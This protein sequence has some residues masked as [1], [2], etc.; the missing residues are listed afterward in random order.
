MRARFSL[1]LAASSALFLLAACT[2][3]TP[4][5]PSAA[6]AEAPAAPTETVAARRTVEVRNPFGNTAVADNLMAD[7][8]FELTGRYDQQPWL[9]FGQGGQSVLNFETGGRCRSGVRC[10]VLGPDEAV[11]GW[12][13]TPAAGKIT[14]ALWAR[15]V[16]GSC[17]DLIVR[18]VDMDKDSN[19]AVGFPAPAEDERGECFFE[20]SAASL[21]G[22]SPAV[23]LEV[24][25]NA[26]AKSIVVDDVVALPVAGNGASLRSLALS[27]ATRA[28]A[29]LPFVAD[30]VKRN[31][32]FG[33]PPKTGPEI[34]A[35]SAKQRRLER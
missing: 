24:A 28:P 19:T 15:P 10:L 20:G 8:D 18:I 26:K 6:P 4:A 33:L 17:K 3:G 23:W 30:W 7:G 32:R 34:P 29:R 11:L 13:A 14:I 35:P 5:A 21:P 2:D 25:G 1:L 22:G 31:R 27:F 16:G 12:M 9:A